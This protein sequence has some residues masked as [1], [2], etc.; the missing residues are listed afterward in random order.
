MQFYQQCKQ[1]Q[2]QRLENNDNKIST[3]IAFDNV[4]KDFDSEIISQV[5]NYREPLMSNDWH[6]YSPLFVAA[7]HNSRK[8]VECLLTTFAN[9]INV[10]NISTEDLLVALHVASF[11]GF[12]KIVELLLTHGADS[13]KQDEKGCTA[14][15][16]AATNGHLQIVELLMEHG[17][18]V[19]I[20]TK[21][22]IT[23]L[24]IACSNGKKEI[25]KYFIDS[26]KIRNEIYN[27][28]EIHRTPL[29]AATRS[30][31]LECLQLLLQ[32]G[33]CDVNIPNSTLATPLWIAASKGSRQAL[34]LLIKYNANI[35][36]SDKQV[37]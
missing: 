3:R 7:G 25:V 17:A 15:F 36:Q 4:F 8:I 29:L 2:L 13:N 21:N 16:L 27:L 19:N 24:R 33:K 12:G 20:G 32:T 18:D 28:I 31:H 14:L 10:D 5:I 9:I 35:E 22:G 23:P 11:K 37:I 34:D 6:N 1:L 30:N 26:N